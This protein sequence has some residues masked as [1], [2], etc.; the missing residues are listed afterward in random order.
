MFC[1]FP[2]QFLHIGI[3]KYFQIT[4]IIISFIKL[5]KWLQV[6]LARLRSGH[7]RLNAHMHRKLNIVPSP[8]CPNGEEY[9]TSMFFWDVTHT[10]QSESHSGHQQLRFTRNYMG[11]WRTRRRPPTSSLLLDWSCRRTRRRSRLS[12]S[13]NLT[14]IITFPMHILVFEIDRL[15]MYILWVLILYHYVDKYLYMLCFLCAYICWLIY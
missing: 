9:Q 14:W 12:T 15:Y 10:N 11:A 4:I 7:N 1:Q 2:F 8:T 5:V 3:L 6:V 13:S